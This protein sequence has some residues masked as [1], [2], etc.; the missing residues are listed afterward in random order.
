MGNF[1]VAVNMA[2]AGAEEG[3]GKEE[4]EEL[5]NY[6]Q[7]I[8]IGG[9]ISGLS[10]ASHLSKNGFNDFKL[11][12]A[13]NR[14][15]GRIATMQLGGSKIELGAHWIHGILGNPLYE[16]AVSNN[17]VDVVQATKPHN[18]VATTEEGRRLPFP[19]LQEIYEAYFWFF[20]RCE[21][22]FLCKYQPPEGIHS[23]GEHVELEISLYLERFPPQ[24]RYLR[25]L[26]FDYLLKRECC[27]TGC[28]SM[29]EIDLMS[30]GSYTELPG[31]NIAL[32]Q[33]YSSILAPI[34]KNI[35]A[36]NILKQHPIKCIHWRYGEETDG[37][38]SDGSDCSVSTV[39][40][41]EGTSLDTGQIKG[42]SS[43]SLPASVINSRRGSQDML[44]KP[45][46]RSGKPSVKVECDN[47]TVFYADQLICT[48]PLGI[49]EKNPDLFNPPLPKEKTRCM[50]KMVYGVVNKIFLAYE[51][52]FLN[53]D[54]S[55]I[56]VLWNKV[57]EK[58][59][60][61]EERWYR[62]IYSFCKV[63]ET[64]LLAWICGDEA[65]FM[66]GLK[67]NVVADACT[68]I[69]KKF[70]AD[71]FIPKP[72][73]CLFTSWFSQPYTGGSYSAIGTGGTQA[74][75]EKIA[76][77]LYT[78]FRKS[79]K[80]PVVAFAGEHCH[81]SFYST[82]HGAYLTGRTAAQL[83]I[84]CA[85]EGTNAAGETTYNLT[86][87]SV[88]DLSTWLEEVSCGD[89]NLDDYRAKTSSSRP[90]RDDGQYVT[91]R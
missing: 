86:D 77:P 21:E 66:E 67:M 28:S 31:G 62:K 29:N 70:L 75:V 91:P 33:G 76:E 40:S 32:P 84:R 6:S 44:D 8:V 45:N 46:Q 43:N 23:V 10:A 74:D 81:P 85:K 73:S 64:V 52:P 4:K 79:E 16:L 34:I 58:V 55:E 25:R 12:E 68:M 65:K 30:I 89:K 78:K 2:T 51:K 49:I 50:K 71:P 41:V 9:G 42:L 37:Y 14:L 80:S 60:P 72:K 3:G 15:G 83:M 87:A 7:F 5:E 36:D 57:D 11:L 18:V 48:M 26:I 17:L 35:P 19:V 82:G 59:I 63:S 1:G 24:Q 54:I 13:R 56:I 38:E 88:S 53:P 90:R 22:Y 27:I 47:G 69:L 61:M 39:K 20:K